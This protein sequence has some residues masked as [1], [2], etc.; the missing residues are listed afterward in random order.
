MPRLRTAIY[1]ILVLFFFSTGAIANIAPN[2]PKR[3]I[4]HGDFF[5]LNRAIYINTK[6]LPK[7]TAIE[8][9][10]FISLQGGSVEKSFFKKFFIPKIVFRQMSKVK[11]AQGDEKV[12]IEVSSKQVLIIY[13]TPRAALRGVELLL[14]II[15]P[16]N[17]INVVD[18]V[19]I[20]DWATRSF[21][22][23][24]SLKND[25]FDLTDPTINKQFIVSQIAKTAPN[26]TLFLYAATPEKWA[27]KSNVLTD[28]N[29]QFNS[30][31]A[32]PN[33]SIEDINQIIEVGQKRGVNIILNV[34]LIEDSEIFK[35]ITGH[36]I[37]SPEGMRFVR[38]II[39][40]YT[41]NLKQ[42]TIAVGYI[43]AGINEFYLQFLNRVQE[44]LGVEIIFE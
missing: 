4:T 1:F 10:K 27:I 35:S 31:I 26:T 30:L 28:A 7:E 43:P 29:D 38:A 21:K 32:K 14:E 20:T 24:T 19:T 41:S 5:P 22:Q 40:E 15:K 36:S 18:G 13:N 34:N 12:R 11:E 39:D 16:R 42:K 44:L 37:Y 6:G 25:G 3:V 9:E 17:G 2:P 8:F 33:Y 23:K